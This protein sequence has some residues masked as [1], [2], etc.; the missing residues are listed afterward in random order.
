MQMK[1]WCIEFMNGDGKKEY[2]EYPQH[3]QFKTKERL[4]KFLQDRKF[5]TDYYVDRITLLDLQKEKEKTA[6]A[7]GKLIYF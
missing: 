1:T 6:D 5:L 7:L 4:L 3:L 2:R